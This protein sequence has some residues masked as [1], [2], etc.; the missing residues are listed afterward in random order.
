MGAG[1]AA[2][3]AG[4]RDW[5]DGYKKAD[6]GGILPLAIEGS[7][8]RGVLERPLRLQT[9]YW[10]TVSSSASPGIGVGGQRS[11]NEVE[12]RR[13]RGRVI[14]VS[15]TPAVGHH[16]E[17]RTRPIPAVQGGIG[18]AAGIRVQR[19]PRT[20]DQ[21]QQAVAA[22]LEPVFPNVGT[23]TRC[24]VGGHRLL[25]M[26]VPHRGTHTKREHSRAF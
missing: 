1:V 11:G 9:G 23:S 2:P 14:F 7:Q 5:L 18:S 19:S 24:G 17:T 25:N 12:S 26:W 3:R 16:A 8:F 6:H 4:S 21:G 10:V 20:P 22:T 15:A 13:P